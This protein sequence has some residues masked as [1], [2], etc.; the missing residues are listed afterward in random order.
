MFLKFLALFVFIFSSY[1]LAGNTETTYEKWEKAPKCRFIHPFTKV[2]KYLS[3]DSMQITGKIV[4]GLAEITFN[5][6]FENPVD[7]ILNLEYNFPMPQNS[8][9]K[10]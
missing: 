2:E 7:T 4:N 8:I 9:H 3:P 5:Q 10:Y 1:S 6:H